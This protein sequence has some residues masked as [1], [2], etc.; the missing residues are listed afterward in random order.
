MDANLF[1]HLLINLRCS[2]SFT[3]P[4]CENPGTPHL[5]VEHDKS[6]ITADGTPSDTAISGYGYS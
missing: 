5:E 3:L 1:M 6:F 4:R 2:Q